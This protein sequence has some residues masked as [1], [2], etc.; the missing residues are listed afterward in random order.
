M[1]GSDNY[2]RDAHYD[3]EQDTE[4]L[5][6][7]REDITHNIAELVAFEAELEWVRR[8]M[9]ERTDNHQRII[10]ISSFLF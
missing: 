10:W 5:N 6:S 1:R 4:R 2:V 3:I 9:E 7:H 8:I